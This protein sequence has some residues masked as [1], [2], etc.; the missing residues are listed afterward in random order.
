MGVDDRHSLGSRYQ[1][2]PDT[3][4][5]CAVKVRSADR[6]PADIVSFACRKPRSA[7]N[8]RD[9]LQTNFGAQLGGFWASSGARLDGSP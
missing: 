8:R 6:R 9:L 7:R 3:G 2:G 5:G 1:A 4:N